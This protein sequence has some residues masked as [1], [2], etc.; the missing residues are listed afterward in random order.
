MAPVTDESDAR[1]LTIR[2]AAAML[3]VHPLT[4][5]NWSEKGTIPCLRTPGGHRRYRV[6]DLRQVLAAPHEDPAQAAAIERMV[7]SA[8]QAAVAAPPR[9]ASAAALRTLRAGLT[10][11]ERRSLAELGRAL[12]SLLI[13]CAVAGPGGTTAGDGSTGRRARASTPGGTL[14]R[15]GRQLGRSYGVAARRLGLA[16]STVVATFSFFQDTVMHALADCDHSRSAA[17]DHARLGRLCGAVL[18]AAV[19]AAEQARP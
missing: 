9:L 2:E 13:E 3:G 10:R 19:T 11:G 17:F 14:L 5:R 4:L 8:V 7:R 15:R 6:R 16:P 12:L 18:L 1:L